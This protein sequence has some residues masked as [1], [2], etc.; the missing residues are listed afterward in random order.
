MVTEKHYWGE[1]TV[2]NCCAVARV[3]NAVYMSSLLFNTLVQQCVSDLALLTL[4]LPF[5]HW[6]LCFPGLY[7]GQTWQELGDCCLRAVHRGFSELQGE[8]PN[9]QSVQT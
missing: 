1:E 6:S 5:P 2:A 4:V 8:T 3:G 9:I 7:L